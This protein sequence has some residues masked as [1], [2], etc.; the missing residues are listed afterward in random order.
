MSKSGSHL[1]KS[2]Q[3]MVDKQMIKIKAE[4]DFNEQIIE[5]RQ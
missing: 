2:Q 3:L 1:V 5:E 4:I